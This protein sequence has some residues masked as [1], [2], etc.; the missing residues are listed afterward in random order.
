MLV[1]HPLI[2]F[3]WFDQ[4]RGTP[5]MTY[6]RSKKFADLVRSI[7]PDIIFNSRLGRLS[8]RLRLD[9][10]QRNPR[11]HAG[12]RLGVAVHDQ[13]HLGLQGAGH[14]ISSRPETLIRNLIDVV[15]KGGNYI[16]NVGP[17]GNGVIPAPEVERLQVMGDWL[18]MNGE[19]IYGAGPTPF[20]AE[21]GSFD[22]AAKDHRGQP[23]F[24][25]KN[26]WRVTTKP[27]RL[28]VHLLEWPAG[29][30]ELP[31]VAG[32]VSKAWLLAARDK[33]LSFTLEGGTVRVQF[34]AQAPDAVVPVL[35]LE[36]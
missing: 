22:P 9:G 18:K 23:V 1:D 36:M 14:A 31:G 13:R 11:S 17:T 19:A 25:A 8:G 34:P 6:E 27:G 28:Y 20:G 32:R 12:W 21:L 33:P 10:R 3:I 29:A 5:E 24:H 16:L 15:S 35:C 2:S 4:A 26:E 30:F 7:R